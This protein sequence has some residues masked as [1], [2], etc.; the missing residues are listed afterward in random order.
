MRLNKTRVVFCI[1]ASF[2]LVFAGGPA[3][4]ASFSSGVDPELTEFEESE[5]ASPFNTDERA[6]YV[7]GFE[8]FDM[9]RAATVGVRQNYFVGRV[10]A[11]WPHE[12]G[13][14]ASAHV[15]WELLRGSAPKLLTTSELWSKAKNGHWI[16][17]AS[18]SASIWP[19][20]MQGASGRGRAAVARARCNGT[21]KTEWFAVGKI[22]AP[23]GI[24]PYGTH[25]SEI[26]HLYCG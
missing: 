13:S 15:T 24:K 19:S 23:G 6:P 21:K 1:L 8:A 3:Y 4:A 12:S 2:S 10:T 16:L 11:H 9:D 17:R 26:R 18:R 14:D 22:Y 20:N 5:V 25:R 7:Y